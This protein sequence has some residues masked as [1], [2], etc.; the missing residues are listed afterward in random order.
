MLLYLMLKMTKPVPFFLISNIHWGCSGFFMFVCAHTH[1]GQCE[2]YLCLCAHAC[3]RV[4]VCLS[5]LKD[6]THP[7]VT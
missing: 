3:V 5:R 6:H 1:Q 2:R 7:V 4:C